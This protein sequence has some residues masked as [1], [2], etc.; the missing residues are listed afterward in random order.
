MSLVSGPITYVRRES[1]RMKLNAGNLML[2][3][4]S[5][6]KFSAA[7]RTAGLH[8]H[9]VRRKRSG[10]GGVYAAGVSALRVKKWLTWED[11]SW[12]LSGTTQRPHRFWSSHHTS[13]TIPSESLHDNDK[14][15]EQHIPHKP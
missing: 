12:F 6:V 3:L 13:R 15:S 2:F 11:W 9:V 1:H 14:P 8:S 5:T 4:M 7:A 10:R